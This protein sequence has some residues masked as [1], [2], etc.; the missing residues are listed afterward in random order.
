MLESS[1]QSSHLLK[2]GIQSAKDMRK[3]VLILQVWGSALAPSTLPVSGVILLH[4]KA[5]C[6]RL[7]ECSVHK[8]AQ[9]LCRGRKLIFAYHVP[10]LS[11]SFPPY[12]L[13]VSYKYSYLGPLLKVWRV[14]NIEII[15][16]QLKY[17]SFEDIVLNWKICMLLK[18]K[19]SNNILRPYWH[20]L[21]NIYV[22]SVFWKIKNYCKNIKHF[23]ENLAVNEL[24]KS[25]R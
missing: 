10:P 12:Q 4:T 17:I 2:I 16:W 8:G 14:M 22:K 11:K 13:E 20:N 5:R 1:S 21:S 6:K 23:N 15:V 18:L 3:D 24:I 19:W 25:S 9:P 7:F